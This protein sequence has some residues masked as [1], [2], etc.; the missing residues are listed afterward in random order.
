MHFGAAVAVLAFAVRVQADEAQCPAI[1]GVGELVRCALESSERV[2][3]IRAEM[4]SARARR[5]VAGRLLPANPVIDLG[6]GYRQ[7]ETRSSDID[8]GVEVA[9]SFEVGGQRGARISAADAELRAAETSARAVGALIAGEVLGA[10]TQVV[11]ARRELA[12]VRE[13]SEGAERLVQVSRARAGKGLAAPLET[14]LAEAARVQALRDER[15]A[16]QELSDA[17]ARLA[18]SVG[19]DSQLALDAELP[20]SPSPRGSLVELEDRAV[21]LRPEIAASRAAVESSSARVLLLRRERIPDVTLGAGARHEELSNIFAAKVSVPIPLFRRNEG[22]IAEQEARTRQAT[23]TAHQEE[24][25][26]RWEVRAAFRSWQRARAAAEAIGPD[27][28]TRLRADVVALRDAYERGRLPL[29]TVL[30]SLREAQSARRFLLEARV[31]A[32]QAA[33]E[34]ARVAALDPCEAGACR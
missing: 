28:E 18:L 22:E 19:R 9:Q 16:A 2:A 21:A 34:L 15:V 27:L 11:R 13:Q 25:R 30:A 31:D 4:D 20:P 17:E 3:R 6:V 7:T 12:L 10:A 33:L 14:E 26:V 32:A 5:D 23:A 1:G 8:R 29:T 24:L